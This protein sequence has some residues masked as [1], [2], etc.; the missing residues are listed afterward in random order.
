MTV[1]ETDLILYTRKGCSLCE[2]AEKLLLERQLPFK[3]VDIG[4]G[5]ILEGQYGFDVPVLA[6]GE[7]TLLKGVFSVARLEKIGL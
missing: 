6:R 7:V 1:Y 4:R 2:K 5:V 3:S